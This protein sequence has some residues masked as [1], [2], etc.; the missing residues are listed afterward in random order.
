MISS[1][2]KDESDIINEENPEAV[3]EVKVTFGEEK[4]YLVKA[5]N[6]YEAMV[7][8]KELHYPNIEI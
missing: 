3:F 8:V 5:A 1:K 2:L 6:S 7:R 4:V